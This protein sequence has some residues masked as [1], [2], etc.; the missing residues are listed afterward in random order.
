MLTPEQVA[1]LKSQLA[2]QI[3]HL[4]E[5]QRAQAQ[6]QIDQMSPEALELMLNQ[7]MSSQSTKAKASKSVFRMIIDGEL[8]SKKINENKNAIAVLEIKPVSKGHVII[9][10]KNHV[11]SPDEISADSFVFIK[12]ISKRIREKLKPKDILLHSSSKSGHSIINIIPIYED[13]SIDSPRIK[14]LD[15]ELERIQKQL[16]KQ[17]EIKQEEKIKP[18]EEEKFENIKFPKKI[19]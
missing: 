18:V 8:P 3:K 15:E 4:P 11:S 10:P 16:E 2:E 6:V 5:A 1:E 17:Q 12:E 7:Q 9:I 14:P 13:E 19:P